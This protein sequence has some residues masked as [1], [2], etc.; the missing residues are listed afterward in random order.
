MRNLSEEGHAFAKR[1][2]T[3]YVGWAEENNCHR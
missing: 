2:E 1:G 3:Q